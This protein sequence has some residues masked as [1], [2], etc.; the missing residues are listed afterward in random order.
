MLRLLFRFLTL[1]SLV[2]T[3]PAGLAS[4]GIFEDLEI[5]D[6]LRSGLTGSLFTDNPNVKEA[7]DDAGVSLGITQIMDYYGNTAG[8]IQQGFVYDGLFNAELEFDLQKTLG[9]SSTKLHINATVTQGQNLSANYVGNIFVASS[10]ADQYHV[11]K[12]ADAWI[13][14]SFFDDTI[15]LRG[16]QMIAQN[17]FATNEAASLFTNA[18]FAYPFIFAVNLPNNGATYV[19]A[20]PGALLRLMPSPNFTWQT[21][22]F[23]AL[24]A[25]TSSSGN[26]YGVEFPLGN[27]AMTWTEFILMPN[28][29]MDTESIPAIYKMGAWYN[30]TTLDPRTVSFN[31]ISY[32]TPNEVNSVKGT[33]SVYLSVDQDIWQNN[34]LVN[35]KIRGFLRAATNPQSNHNLMT[36]YLD[37]GLRFKGL[38]SGRPKDE[39]GIA[40]AWGNLSPAVNNQVRQYNQ[41]FAKSMPLPTSETVFELTYLA[42]IEAW[43]SV[44]PFFQYVVNPG[45]GSANPNTPSQKIP[46]ATIAGLRV[47]I[48]F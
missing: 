15:A 2:I 32:E 18:T 43:W 37:A 11:A 19:D 23:N 31:G 8:G 3:A 41:Y 28:V 29:T 30:P 36:A 6:P 39:F 1:I 16:G 42:P 12:L 27:G 35:Q 17:I 21:S 45:G 13:E 26:R 40:A 4:N 22:V 47:A 38:T 24:P 25:G 9:L 14:R 44:Q 7:L 34:L 10:I 5:G 46:N 33:Y 20:V 48:N